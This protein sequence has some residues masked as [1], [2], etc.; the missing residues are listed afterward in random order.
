MLHPGR[1]TPLSPAPTA[2]ANYNLIFAFFCQ[3]RAPK[4]EALSPSLFFLGIDQFTAPNDGITSS[5]Q[6][7]TRR[8][9]FSAVSPN[10]DTFYW[11]II[12][13]LM[14]GGHQGQGAAHLSLFRWVPFWCPKQTIDARQRKPDGSR[15]AH[16]HGG[17]T[18]PCP[19]RVGRRLL[20]LVVVFLCV[21]CGCI[22]A[23][24]LPIL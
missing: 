3:Q 15:P 6:F 20:M 23:R 10:A 21:L 1:I 16:T 11:L 18:L 7:L 12:V 4:A 22:V 17:A 8:H 24:V 14:N 13:F 19:W 2:Y 5:P 9:L